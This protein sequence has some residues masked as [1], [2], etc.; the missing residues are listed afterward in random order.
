MP[1]RAFREK[2]GDPGDP[3][4]GDVTTKLQELVMQFLHDLPR[5][6]R[7]PKVDGREGRGEHEEV[8]V[9]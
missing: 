6:G 4:E 5:D 2:F 8:K 3:I 9:R 7:P 1:M